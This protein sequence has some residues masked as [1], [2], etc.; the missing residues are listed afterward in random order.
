MQQRGFTLVEVLVALAI[1]ALM[2]V[3]AYRGL[4][5][6]MRTREHL[7]EDNRR[8][9]DLALTLQQ[10]G[11]DLDMAVDRPVRDA[12]DLVQPALLGDPEAFG[13]HDALLSVSRMG[14]AW[15]QGV[16]ADVQ[17]HGYRLRQGRIEQLLWPVL[18]RAPRTEPEVEV[19]LDGVR[20][21]ELRYL[22]ASGHWQPRWPMP[23][24]RAGLPAALEVLIE[25]DEGSTVT[26]VFALP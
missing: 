17:R 4:D 10:I 11:L 19:L 23:G 13:E 8:W 6:V 18:D 5:A 20:R 3:F 22:D 9:R 16:A 14:D 2:A 12:A 21:F 25:L 15:Y 26:R 7:T 1:F 24:E